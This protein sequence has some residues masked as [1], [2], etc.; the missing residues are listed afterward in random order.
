MTAAES[1]VHDRAVWNFHHKESK[2]HLDNVT[3]PFDAFALVT[4]H[5]I[6]P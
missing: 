2:R 4:A 6:A 5:G 3:K 1:D